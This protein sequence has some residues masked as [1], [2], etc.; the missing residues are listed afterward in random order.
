MFRDIIPGRLREGSREGEH[1]G[2]GVP[3]M[4]REAAMYPT[5]KLSTTR[6]RLIGTSLTAGALASIG[7]TRGTL[8]Q[9]GGPAGWPIVSRTPLAITRPSARNSPSPR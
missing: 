5:P 2:L 3:P 8:A 9:A 7:G 1:A 4:T 6:R